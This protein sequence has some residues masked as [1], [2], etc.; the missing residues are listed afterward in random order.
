[1][2]D[3][4]SS[5]SSNLSG[6][7]AAALDGCFLGTVACCVSWT[8]SEGIETSHAEN[9]V[10]LRTVERF[11]TMSAVDTPRVH[12]V[13]SRVQYF[14]AILPNVLSMATSTGANRDSHLKVSGYD[15]VPY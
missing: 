11:P 14:L 15:P 4:A 5:L 2:I 9:R 12:A 8:E 10:D 7:K 13:L 1:M 3:A 6:T